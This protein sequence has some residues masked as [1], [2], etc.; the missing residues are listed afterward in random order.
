MNSSNTSTGDVRQKS[1]VDSTYGPINSEKRKKKSIKF[2]KKF[3]NPLNIKTRLLQAKTSI[4]EN[5][6]D[7]KEKA[8]NF[9]GKQKE[10]IVATIEIDDSDESDCLPV[11]LPAPPLISLDS[12]DEE[13]IGRMKKTYS[14]SSSS[15]ISDDFITNGE[16]N[17]VI[18]AFRQNELHHASE[19]LKKI[20]HQRETMEKAKTLTKLLP[21]SSS[22]SSARSSCERTFLSTS[23]NPIKI[24]QIDNE[25]SIYGAK[26][27]NLS[28]QDNTTNTIE[29]SEEDEIP[30]VNATKRRRKS[31]GSGKKSTDQESDKEDI[32]INNLET[33]VRVKKRSRLITPRYNDDEFGSMISKIVNNENI[34]ED[35]EVEKELNT[36]NEKNKNDA[37]DD[38]K[39]FE[40]FHK[41][42]SVP[43]YEDKRELETE[44]KILSDSDDSMKNVSLPFNCDLSLNVTKPKFTQ[45]EYIRD[46]NESTESIAAMNVASLDPEIGWNDEMKYFYYGSWGDENFNLT[47][48][49]NLMS[50]NPNFWK[51]SN[52]DR[53]RTFDNNS[54]T[55]CKNCNDFGHIAIRCTQKK[56][57]VCFMCGEENHRETRCPNSICL[58]VS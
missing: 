1:L 31:T 52:A 56:K 30:C 55:R 35:S 37:S 49:Y 28:T 51:I 43:D 11:E 2:S 14:P 36:E 9:R 12:S 4:L 50:K 3:L 38:C 47:E 26:M 46:A 10:K 17:R 29:S 53:M 15:I 7:K 33:N 34:E 19:K 20:I 39:I 25:D 8:F 6:Q 27:R 48:L 23:V 42:S 45:H 24:I 41:N 22:S 18:T 57:I 13:G 32:K 5:F 21:S 54:R 40:V 16:K 44:E 58:R